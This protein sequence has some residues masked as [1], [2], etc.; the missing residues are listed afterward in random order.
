MSL[1]TAS[2]HGM[3]SSSELR[4][5]T[6]ATSAFRSQ[7]SKLRSLPPRHG[8]RCQTGMQHLVLQRRARRGLFCC[9][10]VGLRAAGALHACFVLHAS[11]R[12]RYPARQL[13]T[14]RTAHS[15]QQWPDV[16]RCRCL[17]CPVAVADMRVPL[18]LFVG[19]SEVVFVCGFDHEVPLQSTWPTAKVPAHLEATVC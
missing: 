10:M 2:S 17:V 9:C 19:L 14:M 13:R 18:R 6:C 8:I 3:L 5:S 16:S 11:C 1:F 12:S 7:R 4:A 15:T